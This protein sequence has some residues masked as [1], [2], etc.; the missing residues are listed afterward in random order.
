M[1]I[2]D[3][4]MDGAFALSTIILAGIPLT[5]LYNLEASLLQAVGNSVSAPCFSAFQQCFECGTGFLVY[6]TVGTGSAGVASATVLA[7]GISAGIGLGYIVRYYPELRFSKNEFKVK[8]NFVIE[9]FF[10]GLSMGMMNAIYCIGS[11]ILQSSI[12][13]LGSVYIAAQVGGRR[14]A[15]LFYIPGLALGTSTAIYASQNYGAGLGKKNPQR[16]SDSN[17]S[18][19]DLV[20]HCTY[21]YFYPGTSGD[22]ASY[23]KRNPE[24][25]SN[26]LLYLRVSIPMI[27]PMAVLVIL[28][29]ALQGMRH[30]KAPLICSTLELIGKVI[31]AIWLVPV[32][33]LYRRMHLRTCDVGDL[34]CV[35]CRGAVVFRKEFQTAE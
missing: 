18:V 16:L 7:Q 13:A 14:L 8:K 17:S 30:L 25:I 6:G 15:E 3:D 34:L 33:G 28:R 1:Q 12:N 20:D 11:V 29:N 4:V 2:P 21:V 23:R 19:W 5:M 27:P 10:S 22:P 31:F 9:M 24:V 26:G 32:W 35:Y